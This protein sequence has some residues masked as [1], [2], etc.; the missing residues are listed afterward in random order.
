MVTNDDCIE[1][2]ISNRNQIE[3]GTMQQ[4]KLY[5]MLKIKTTKLEPMGQVTKQYLI[6]SRTRVKRVSRIHHRTKSENDFSGWRPAIAFLYLSLFHF[7]LCLTFFLSQ[8][9]YQW[10]NDVTQWRQAMHG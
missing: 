8:N 7:L 9:K 6:T 5:H 3:S 2:D 4:R 10:A 1:T